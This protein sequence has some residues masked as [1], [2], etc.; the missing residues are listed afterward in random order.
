MKA[1]LQLRAMGMQFFSDWFVA[2]LQ[3]NP[4]QDNSASLCKTCEVNQR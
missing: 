3:D 1:Q 2:L 4:Q